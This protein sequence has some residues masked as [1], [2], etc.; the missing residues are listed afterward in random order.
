MASNID[1]DQKLLKEAMK[2]GDFKTKKEAINYILEEFV[3]LK[4]QVAIV[5]LF[6]SVKYD[7]DYD[8]KAARNR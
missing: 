2:L 1:F 3:K 8:Y 7:K 4:K 6:G 5:N